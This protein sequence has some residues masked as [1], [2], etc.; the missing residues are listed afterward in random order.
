MYLYNVFQ[1]IYILNKK[2]IKL[3]N[4]LSMALLVISAM[5]VTI[6][7]YIKHFCTYNDTEI[8]LQAFSTPASNLEIIVSILLNAAFGLFI[9]ILSI[10]IINFLSKKYPQKFSLSSPKY[11]TSLLGLSILIFCFCINHMGLELQFVIKNL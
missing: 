7:R 3:F 9:G 10:C 11:S 5:I 2:H 4:L 1:E 8:F 6:G